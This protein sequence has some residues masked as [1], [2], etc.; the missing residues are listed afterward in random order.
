ME[1]LSIE[2][3]KN[4]KV[5]IGGWLSLIVSMVYIKVF[6]YIYETVL[7]FLG[8]DILPATILL[9]E[10]FLNIFFLLYAF[11]V[12]DYI[13][14]RSIQFKRSFSKFIILDPIFRIIESILL[15]TTYKEKEILEA[16]V[17]NFIYNLIFIFLSIIILLY[18]KKSQRVLLTFTEQKNENK[19]TEQPIDTESSQDTF[20]IP[21]EQAIKCPECGRDILKSSSYCH[22]CKSIISRDYLNGCEHT[23]QNTEKDINAV[24]TI[25]DNQ[26]KQNVVPLNP[27]ALIG[28]EILAE[29][30]E[31]VDLSPRAAA[32]ALENS[33]IGECLRKH[34]REYGACSAMDRADIFLILKKLN[35]EEQNR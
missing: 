23:P 16:S 11:K 15:F 35:L 20:S 3:N 8:S 33:P 26:K 30:K 1:K 28:E 17:E 29:F 4:G 24:V 5:K 22:Y 12:I 32:M 21:P 25:V 19:P 2:Y 13:N 34:L 6:G 31:L 27:N 18:I 10:L 9:Y 14:L 7:L